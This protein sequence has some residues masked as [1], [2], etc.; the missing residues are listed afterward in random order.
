MV[1]VFWIELLRSPASIPGALILLLAIPAAVLFVAESDENALWMSRFMFVE[2]TR[3]L[4]PLLTI[5]GAA[6]LL[7]PRMAR[8]W[9]TLPARRSEWLLACSV[10]AFTI[11]LVVNALLFAGSMLA[12]SMVDADTQLQVTVN[13]SQVDAIRKDG[14]RRAG[15]PASYSW[16]NPNYQEVLEF[17]VDPGNKLDATIHFEAAL[18]NVQAPLGGVPFVAYGL[19]ENSSSTALTVTTAGRRKAIVSG[20]GKFSRVQLKAN[21]PG[22]IVGVTA[23]DIHIATDVQS[24]LLSMLAIFALS[25]AG[26]LLLVSGVY[27]FRSLSTAPTAALAGLFLFSAMTL[28]PSLAPTTAM[29]KA[30]ASAMMQSDENST[31]LS[32]L[33]H[34]PQ[35]FPA[36]AFDEFLAGRVSGPVIGDALLRATMSFPLL[37]AGALLFRRRELAK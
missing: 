37:L 29:A 21:D 6:F 1:K 12:Q 31:D 33:E 9:S 19:G 23:E 13:A 18:S 28:L 11:V 7:R 24:S 26:T 30:R 20:E 10:T 17:N 8:G 25:L 27:A 34:I 36:H 35:I 32:A 4:I 14:S 5:M 15:K 22:L 2:A 3:A 16:M